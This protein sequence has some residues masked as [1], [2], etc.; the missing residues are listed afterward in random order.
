MN[1]IIIAIIGS[2]AL[3]TLISALVS[4][5]N[6]KKKSEAGQTKALQLL[7][8]GEIKRTG[9]DYLA[10]GYLSMEDLKAYTEMYD[11]YHDPLDKGGLGGN[12]FAESIYAQVKKLPIKEA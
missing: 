5:H 2:G 4:N 12:G 7:L 1:Q 10:Q 11:C 8:L 9:R 3:S 6:M